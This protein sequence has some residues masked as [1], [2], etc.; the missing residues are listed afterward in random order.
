[1]LTTRVDSWLDGRRT[2]PMTR[3]TP[4]EAFSNTVS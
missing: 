1:V 3:W 4:T 2:R